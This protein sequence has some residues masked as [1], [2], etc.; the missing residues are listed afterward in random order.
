MFGGGQP[1]A[2]PDVVKLSISGCL[3]QAGGVGIDLTQQNVIIEIRPDT[4]AAR[5][6][7]E[8]GGLQV[9]D[10]V[11]SVDGVALRG[12]VL[13]E[14]IQPADVHDFEVERTQGWTGFSIEDVAEGEDDD[15]FAELNRLRTVVVQKLDGQLGINPEVHCP[16]G[17]SAVIKVAKVYPG[18]R[19]SACGVVSVGDVI[20]S[21]SGQSLACGAGENPLSNATKVLAEVPDGVDISLELESDVRG[22]TPRN[23]TATPHRTPPSHPMGRL[24]RVR[25]RRAAAGRLSPSAL[26][27]TSLACP[28]PSAR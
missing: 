17:E 25:V 10:R 26:P 19:A 6:A 8:G 3:P 1:N 23:P 22:C 28:V 13:T 14:V 12:R 27:P 5:A 21:I 4:A 20:R 15:G 2:V 16:D 9:G 7:A 18:T 24:P 11:L